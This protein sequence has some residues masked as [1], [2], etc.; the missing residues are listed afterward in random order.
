MDHRAKREDFV[1]DVDRFL[2]KLRS[3]GHLAIQSYGGND[4]NCHDERIENSEDGT[5]D[6]N[7]R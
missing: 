5:I 6:V 1:L 2:E 7:S 3:H 4:E